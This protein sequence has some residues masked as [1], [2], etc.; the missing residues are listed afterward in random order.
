MELDLYTGT[1]TYKDIEFSF[2]F[3]NEELRLIPP[4][5]KHH[6]VE[7]WFMKEIATGTYTFGEPVYIEDNS[8][9][10]KCNETG[11]TMVFLPKRRSVGRYNSVLIVEI[12]AY[13]LQK[14]DREFIDRL[15]FS[16]DEIDCIFPTT[17]ALKPQKWSENGCFSV[18]TK[19]FEGTTTQKQTFAVD[20]KNISVYFGISRTSNVKIGKPPLELHSVMFFEFDKISDYSFILRLWR[21]AK[22]F[23]QYLCYRKNVN[24]S[25]VDIASPY[26]DGKHEPFATLYVTGEN[27]NN[28]PEI[29]NKHRYIQQSNINGREG[30]ILSDIASDKIYLRHLPQSYKNGRHI[31]AARFVMITAALEWTFNKNYPEGIT[32]KS[33]TIKAEETAATSLQELID[34]SKGKLKNIYKFLKK[35]IGTDS[36]QTKIEQIGKDYSEIIDVFG[37]RLYSLNHEMLKYSEMGNRLSEQRNNYAHGNLDKDFIGLS[38]LDLMY[39]EQVIYAMQLKEYGLENIEI[40][41]GINAL[42]GCSLQ[43]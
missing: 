38:L 19:D 3:V 15:S 7:H 42:F 6:E 28:E 23:I 39:A 34:N 32:K 8:L 36:L 33:A 25:K 12:E 40:Q 29:L 37:N 35:L 14:F 16:G 22:S 30:N 31:D 21:I 17:Q 26:K 9:I 1:L 27:C 11:Q 13:I 10:G 5:D 20:G 4:K 18:E 43:F 24:L 41:R 2:S